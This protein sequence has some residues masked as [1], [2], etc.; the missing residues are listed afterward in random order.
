MALSATIRNFEIELAHI[1]NHVYDTLT[2]KVA[3][4]PSE[5]NERVAVRVLARALA[6][7][8][9][10]EF[11]RGL[12]TVEDPALWLKDP[13]GQIV[14]WIDVGAPSAQRLHKA[15]KQA[16]RVSVYS[17]KNITNLQNE[18]RG[19]K[20]HQAD[21]I[22]LVHLDTAFIATLGE[23]MDKQNKWSVTVTEGYLS[24]GFGEQTADCQI[25]TSTVGSLL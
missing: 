24:V 5:H 2:F 15:S 6:H 10:L 20:I 14:H 13:M 9:G 1:D 4:H 25:Q 3:Q 11:G 7:E 19:Q 16:Q 18:W 12:S 17:D 22:A 8:E 23:H 21:S